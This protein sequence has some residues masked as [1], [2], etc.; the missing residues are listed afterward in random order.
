MSINPPDPAWFMDTDAT[1]HM[2]SS[3][4]NFLSYFNLSNHHND[5]VV[6][7]GHTILI[8]GYVIHAPRIFKNPISVWKFTTDKFVT[9]EFDPFGFS[10]KDFQTGRQIMRCE[11]RSD[12]YPITTSTNNQ[13]Q[14]FTFIAIS[15]S[16]WHDH[17]GH[18]G[19]QVI[20]VPR[21]NKSI[22][23]NRISTSRICR[24][25]VLGKNVKLP[26]VS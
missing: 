23:C 2:I 11:S 22:D 13:A 8:R 12:L 16:L 9:I 5:I 1:S 4:G 20:D 18:P 21:H 25:C 26:F 24:S 7:N 14:P 19:S 17:L 15:S 6:R 3:N 10:V